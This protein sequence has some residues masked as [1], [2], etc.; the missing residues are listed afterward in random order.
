MNVEGQVA[1]FPHLSNSMVLIT[2]ATWGSKKSCSMMAM[3]NF[4]V[5]LGR[6]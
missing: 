6:S 1:G 3:E 2:N 4:Q 5:K